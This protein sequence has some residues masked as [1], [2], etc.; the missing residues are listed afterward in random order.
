[1]TDRR[2]TP[3][4]ARVAAAHLEGPAPGIRPVS[5]TSRQIGVSVVDLLDNPGGQRERQLLWGDEVTVYETRKGW[6]FVQ[7]RKDGYVGYVPEAALVETAPAT[8][9]LCTPASHAY[10][11]P[12]FKSPELRGLSLGS[13]LK[14][15]RI[16]DG[17]AET[18]SGYIPAQHIAPLS[19]PA[20]DPVAIAEMFLGTPYLWGGN[21]RWGIDCSGLVQAAF[22]ACGIACPADSDQQEAELGNVLPEGADPK[23]GD[24]LFWKGHVAMV[25]DP[26]TLLH[27]NAHHMSVAHEPLQAAIERIEAQG[28]GQVTAHKRVLV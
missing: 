6:C 2:L 24:L 25:Q 5:G 28:D 23:R 26:D 3:A 11:A 13:R 19:E 27:A 14:V 15:D 8:H 7:V 21:S 12:D 18:T 9:W 20:S 10:S 1:M 22:L 4:N 16:D 17:F